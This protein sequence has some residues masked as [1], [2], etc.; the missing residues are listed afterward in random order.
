[1]KQVGEPAWSVALMNARQLVT[2]LSKCHS[3]LSTGLD[4]RP[5]IQQYIKLSKDIMFVAPTT[6]QESNQR[7]RLGKQVVLALVKTSFERRDSERNQR[8]KEL[9]TSITG[10]EKVQAKILR[11]IRKAEALK[12]VFGKIRNLRNPHLRQGLT[13]IEIPIHQGEDPRS[14]VEWKQI[15]VPTEVLFHLQQRNREHFGQAQGTPFTINPLAEELGFQGNGVAAVDIL[16][17]TYSAPYNMDPNVA[18][19]LSHLQQT[20]QMAALESQPTISEEDYVSKLLVWTEST[21]MSPSGLHLGHYKALTAN[22]QYSNV[23]NEGGEETEDSQNQTQWN[24]MQSRM[25]TLHVQMLNYALERGYSYTRWQTVIN[26]ILFKD[27][28]NV[29]IHRT[30]VIHIYEA[31]YNLTLGIKWRAALYKAEELKE[32]NAGQ[33]GSRPYRNAVDPVLIEELQFEI[34]RASRKTMVQTN[35]DAMSCY[36]RVIPNLA[37]LVS[38]KFGVSDKNTTTNAS[39]LEKATYHIR[40]EMGVAETGYGHTPEWPI[41]G[42]GQGSGNSPMIWCFL[43]CVLF[44]CYDIQ[45]HKAKYCNPDRSEP[46]ELGM[47]G[48]VDDCNGQTNEFHEDETNQTIPTILHNLQSNAQLWANLLGASGGALELSKCSSHIAKWQFSIQGDPI[49]T[50][51]PQIIQQPITVVDRNTAAVHDMSFLSPFEAHKTLGHYKEPAGSQQEQFRRLRTKSDSCTEFLWQCQM[52]HEESWTFY[53]ACYLPSIGYPLSCSS[54]TFKQ[55]DRVQ[56]KAMGIIV[57]KCGYNR[58]TKKEILYGP[59]CYGGANFRHLYVQQGASRSSYHFLEALASRDSGGKPFAM[60]VGLDTKYSRNFMVY[61]ARCNNSPSTSRI[62]MVGITPN[63]LGY[64]S[65]SNR[66]RSP[67]ILSKQREHDSYLMDHILQQ[68]GQFTPS[69]IRRLNY[70][71]LYLQAVTMSDITDISGN[72]LDVSIRQGMPSEKSST[73]QW[74]RVNQDRPSDAIWKLWKKA[75]LIWS[76]VEGKLLQPLGKWLIPSAAQ[77]NRHFAYTY[78]DQ[79]A[80]RS[81]DGYHIYTTIPP[82]QCY[83]STDTILSFNQLPADAH[84]R[85]SHYCAYYTRTWRLLAP[86]SAP[87]TTPG[88]ANTYPTFATYI[89]K[90]EVWEYELLRHVNITTDPTT[91]CDSLTQGL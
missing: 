31:D 91:F 68:S 18:L 43:S 76:T 13:R 62:K 71:R 52:T 42:T 39:T 2:I 16:K 77:R 37:M 48:F 7:L 73:T 32:L 33:Y 11:R 21:T 75:N 79:L 85:E 19:L 66:S 14:C 15:D 9:E 58:N 88:P 50:S 83:F 27:M 57:A 87:Y 29:R 46:L 55:L 35:Y 23:D 49:L 28:D 61:V 3:M 38:R 84:P 54:L 72:K 69:Q 70:C 5:Q 47:I 20:E 26:T 24:H 86:S 89:T 64:H 10:G 65:S 90:F 40:T 17:G 81:G 12:K 8:I 4:H 36:D 1:M 56:R 60:C 30:R 74:L 63:I 80:I 45:S 6:R 53:Y 22:H 25:L 41:Y 44:D 51:V 59:L 78:G 34:S 67:G 82:L